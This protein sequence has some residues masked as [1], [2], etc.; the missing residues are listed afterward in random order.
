MGYNA[1]AGLEG[2]SNSET[3]N[4]AAQITGATGPFYARA[5]VLIKYDGALTI[6]KQDFAYS[7]DNPRGAITLYGEEFYMAGNSDS[8][9]NTDGATG[10]GLTIGVRL[11]SRAR[12]VRSSSARTSPPTGRMNRQAAHQGQQ[13]ARH[14]HLRRRLPSSLAPNLRD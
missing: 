5:V 6:T 10:P 1:L 3:T 8:T 9:L 13:L 11:G 4:P 7:G 14:R 12:P 2:V